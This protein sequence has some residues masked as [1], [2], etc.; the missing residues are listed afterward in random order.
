MTPRQRSVLL[1]I[2]DR[3]RRAGGSPSYA[4]IAAGV[5]LKSKGSVMVIVDALVRRGHL[6][7]LPRRACG[8]EVIRLPDA[9]SPEP[10]AVPGGAA[11]L[12]VM[13]TIS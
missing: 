8:L 7:R 2:D 12:P 1:F 10:R 3:I 9:P 13:G 4:T 11:M 6:R 5:G